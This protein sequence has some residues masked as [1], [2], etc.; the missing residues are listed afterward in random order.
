MHLILIN[1]KQAKP[2]EE[3]SMKTDGDEERGRRRNCN[4][5]LT[6][7]MHGWRKIRR[8]QWLKFN[9]LVSVL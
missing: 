2:V 5:G 3:M 1:D 8:H 9:R 7:R 6:G 4:G